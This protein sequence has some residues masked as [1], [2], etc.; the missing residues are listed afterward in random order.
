MGFGVGEIELAVQ[1][2]SVVASASLDE[3]NVQDGKL[4]DGD[5]G[6]TMANGWKEAE[7]EQLP[8]DDLSKAFLALSKAFQRVSSSSF[9]TLIATGLMA[10]AKATKGQSTIHYSEIS[11]L[12]SVARDAMIARG[13][14][15]LGQKSLLDII[16]ATA[17]ATAGLTDPKE[18]AAA[19]IQAV[20]DTLNQFRDMQAG[21]GRARMYGESSIGIDD[22]GMLAFQRMLE[23]LLE[24]SKG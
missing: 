2:I 14:G 12:L 19:S 7:K 10:A 8:A 1:R 15:E 20:K 24:N 13:K 5:L 6:I 17:K 21:L 23:G 22:P 16:D 4:G 11:E 9:G 3:L 18:I